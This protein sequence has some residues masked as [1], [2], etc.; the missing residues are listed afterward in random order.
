MEK[1]EWGPKTTKWAPSH[2]DPEEK[3]TKETEPALSDTEATQKEEAK[4]PTRFDATWN[5]STRGKPKRAHSRRPSRRRSKGGVQELRPKNEEKGG[6]GRWRV[7]GSRENEKVAGYNLFARLRPRRRLLGCAHGQGSPD[8][9]GAWGR[10]F[11][12]KHI[13]RGIPASLR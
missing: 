13:W 9:R 8:L 11:R 2:A 6:S 1:N 12:T 4:K 5:R 10:Y 7:S 3:R